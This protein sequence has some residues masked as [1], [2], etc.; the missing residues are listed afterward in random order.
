M[1]SQ[2]KP[3]PKASP[4]HRYLDRIQEVLSLPTA[5]FAEHA[6]ISYVEDFVRQ[7]PGVSLSRD[8]AGN[9][10]LT[11]GNAAKSGDGR[12][13]VCI[14]AHMDHPGFVAD[15]M[16][17]DGLLRAWWRGGVP[18]ERFPGAK[19]RFHVDGRWIKAEVVETRVV[20]RDGR[21]R[22]TT[23][24]LRPKGEIPRFSLGMWDFP[25]PAFRGG[26][27]HARACDD[28]A[29]VA[30]ILC[31]VDDL[32][33]LN[34]EA[35]ACFL[36]TRAEEVGFVGAM[37]ACRNGL[38]PTG[39]LVVNV[40]TSSLRAGAIPGNGPVL[41]VG[42]K[43]SVF[44]PAATA[45]CEDVAERLQ[46]RRKGFAF[47]RKLMDGGTC[48]ASVFCQRGFDATGI[49]LALGNYHNVDDQ[50]PRLSPEYVNL[51]DFE[52]MVLWFTALAESATEYQ[53]RDVRLEERLLGLEKEYAK[54]LAASVNG[55]A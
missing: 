7:R 11:L 26:A 41:R 39:I 15:R 51:K 33:R 6:V 36:L 3:S 43:M 47:Q 52:N 55:P 48:E 38:I 32:C 1:A 30:A 25:D 8:L 10:L 17:K 37:A 19:V 35:S 12:A 18:P 42:D 23:V 24:T 28:L 5:P 2:A 40:E 53:G 50:R 46:K 45:F 44:T 14:T 20:K 29:G 13:G 49:C 9:L 16:G 27:V 21:K 4:P 22:V 54:L 31:A 34:R